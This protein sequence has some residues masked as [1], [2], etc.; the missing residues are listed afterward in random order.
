MDIKDL[1]KPKTH[2]QKGGIASSADF[3]WGGL[4]IVIFLVLAGFAVF[5]LLIFIG[6]TK[7]PIFEVATSN[8]KT[9]IINKDRVNAAL[10]HFSDRAK[11]STE[12]MDSPVPVVDP[13]L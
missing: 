1:F 13:S 9:Q 2:F 11:K 3:F 10:S 7:Q 8:G 4:L 6:V 12:I 5:C